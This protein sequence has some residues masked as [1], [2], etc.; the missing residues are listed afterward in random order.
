M[1]LNNQWCPETQCDCCTVGNVGVG[2]ILKQMIRINTAESEISAFLFHTVV[3]LCQNQVPTLPTMQLGNWVT[4][5]EEIDQIACSFLWSCKIQLN[6]G[7]L[8]SKT[9]C[10]KTRSQYAVCV[11][12]SCLIHKKYTLKPPVKQLVIRKHCSLTTKGVGCKFDLELSRY[13]RAAVPRVKTASCLS[14]PPPLPST[15]QIKYTY[16]VSAWEPHCQEPRRQKRVD[17]KENESEIYSRRCSVTRSALCVCTYVLTLLPALNDVARSAHAL[18][19]SIH[20]FT[21]YTWAAILYSQRTKHRYMCTSRH[22][23][24]RPDRRLKAGGGSLDHSVLA[25]L[26]ADE[27]FF[28]LASRRLQPCCELIRRVWCAAASGLFTEDVLPKMEKRLNLMCCWWRLNLTY[29]FIIFF[30]LCFHH[31]ELKRVS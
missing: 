25:L 19:P 26:S 18:L 1:R 7:V 20:S 24:D 2:L 15:E 29:S 3:F 21:N 30:R 5:V 17:R 9:T 23:P 13:R 4:S 8:L 11:D 31:A 16:W 27:K 28:L 12:V 10:W 14:A 22:T 6:S